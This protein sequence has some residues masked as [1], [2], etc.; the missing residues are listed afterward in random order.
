M[1][2]EVAGRGGDGAGGGGEGSEMGQEVGEVGQEGAAMVLLVE[3]KEERWGR[4]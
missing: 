4:R 2:Q 3:T 1:G